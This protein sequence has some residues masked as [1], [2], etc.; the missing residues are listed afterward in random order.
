M[1][2]FSP[3]RYGQGPLAADPAVSPR[4]PALWFR[5]TLSD[6]SEAGGP[7]RLLGA[8]EEVLLTVIR[9]GSII[10][11]ESI[12]LGLRETLNHI[13]VHTVQNRDWRAARTSQTAE[14]TRAARTFWGPGSFWGLRY[15]SNRDGT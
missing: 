13:R 10:W 5:L 3:R 2:I 9:T 7:E 4:P 11:G 1:S 14:S 8:S 12:V 6:A 15:P